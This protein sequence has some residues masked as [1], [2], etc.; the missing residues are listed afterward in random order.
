MK[1]YSVSV[2]VAANNRT[3][4]AL[5]AVA[6]LVAGMPRVGVA[7]GDGGAAVWASGLAD[8]DLGLCKEVI[9]IQDVGR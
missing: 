9:R 4:T 1:T 5:R 8:V 2:V 3:I 6:H 7:G